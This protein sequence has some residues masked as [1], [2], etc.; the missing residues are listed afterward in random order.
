VGYGELRIDTQSRFVLRTGF[1]QVSFRDQSSGVRR[2]RFR[3]SPVEPDCGFE[4]EPRF[5][6]VLPT[7]GSPRHHPA[8]GIS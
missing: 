7:I 3:K 4:L 8:V 1:R 6:K 5:R 2:A